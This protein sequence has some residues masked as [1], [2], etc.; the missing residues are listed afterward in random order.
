MESY[1]QIEN[2][3]KR[4]G[5]LV[6]FEGLDISIAQDEKVGLIARNGYGK[7]TLM[8]IITGKEDY[9]GGAI[10]F[11]N[12]ISVSYLVQEP[13][14]PQGITVL[15]ACFHGESPVLA[16]IREYEAALQSGNHAVIQQAM[17]K[18]DAHDAWNYE[19][20]AKQILTQLQI[21]EFDKPVQLLS[22]GQLKRVALANALIN[23]PQLLIMDEPTNHLDVNITLW[24]EEWLQTNR[25][26]LL[27]VT[28]DRY[29]LDR[30]CNRII[31][32]DDGK[33]YSYAGD[34]SYYLE[35]RG[36]R[37]AAEQS[38]AERGENLYRKELDWMRRMPCARA[39]KAR[40]RKEAFY[41]LEERL[42]KR[43]D[44]RTVE[45]DVKASYIGKKI[46]EIQGLN[47]RFGEK[48]ILKDFSYIFTKYEKVG[49]IGPNGVG[50]STFIKMLLG[51]VEPDSGVIDRGTTL[52]IGYYSQDGLQFKPHDKVI[53][54]VT[55]I[56]E[57]IELDSGHRM[58][59]SQFLQKFLFAPKTQ[60]KYV[61][62][63]SGGEKR[64]LYL[65]TILMRNPNFLILDEPTNDLDIMT[66]QVLEEYLST[67]KGSLIVV[68]HDR[69]FMDR[70]AQ[71][72][73]VFEGDGVVTN[74]PSSYSDYMIWTKADA[75]NRKMEAEQQTKQNKSIQ[76]ENGVPAKE[77]TATPPRAKQRLSFKEKRELE[78]I[79]AELQQ[80]EE[81][82]HTLE[83]QMNSGSLDYASLNEKA[84]RVAAIIARTDQ[85]TARWMELS[86]L[87]E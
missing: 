5:D 74:F 9:Q 37:L 40:F 34:Y 78:Q 61:E 75:Q 52:R 11:R 31:E 48:I 68:S 45:L 59:A 79:E 86:E 60:Y 85:I 22:G 82:Q 51:E 81:E 16:T 19:S 73:F 20:R 24:L 4:F 55:S 10:T 36:E 83:S 26:T 87:A 54:V 65:C 21:T 1:L 50:K 44:E 67:F 7:S 29:L 8:N 71:H 23:E 84:Q 13:S 15:E 58:S 42:K 64:R 38:A 18:M 69:Y 63:L 27:L 56:A 14:F 17:N 70:V 76:K 43:R 66:L 30:V 49:I 33:A 3:S 62:R 53:D 35:K 46:F 32:I 47:K 77:N 12:D 80:L 72:L 25:V 41:E 28:H 6:L 39:T 2:L 57:Y